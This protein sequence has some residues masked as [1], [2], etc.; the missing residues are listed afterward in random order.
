M[1]SHALCGQG[2]FMTWGHQGKWDRKWG[3]QQRQRFLPTISPFLHTSASL[4]IL[5]PVV[6]LLIK[7]KNNPLALCR[8]F[9]SANPINIMQASNA[10]LSFLV[11]EGSLSTLF[12]L[13]AYVK[14][15]CWFALMVDGHYHTEKRKIYVNNF[16]WSRYVCSFMADCFTLKLTW[17]SPVVVLIHSIL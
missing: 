15:W 1:S 2:I 8:K 13:A 14:W 7:I 5:W 17:A 9:L 16:A 12:F 10:Q 11:Q 4:W 6:T 3:L